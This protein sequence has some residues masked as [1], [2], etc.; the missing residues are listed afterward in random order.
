MFQRLYD[1]TMS[2]ARQPQAELWLAFVSFVESS[3]FPIPADVLFVPMVAARR[4]RAWRLAL[5]A[6]IAS[7]LGGIAG[8]ALG[9][10]A[11]DLIA[12]PLLE[13]YGKLEVMDRLRGESGVAA[14][15]VMLVTSGMMHLPPMKVVT[16]LSGMISFPLP[17]FI[18]SAIVAR[19][20]RFYILAWLIR[21][22]GS[23]IA[24]ALRGRL[25]VA[26]LAVALIAG[27]GWLLLRSKT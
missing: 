26:A 22:H 20:A 19:G 9:H 3:V 6:T 13:F 27:A 18:V 23:R 2:L 15:L 24:G 16:I 5:I 11:Y 8:W 1:W 10:F 25:G 7:V 4:D 12:R 14:I 21:R 17:L